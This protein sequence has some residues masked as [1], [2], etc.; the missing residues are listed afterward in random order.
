MSGVRADIT[1]CPKCGSG[2]L[3]CTIG[4]DY[5]VCLECWS[6]WERLRP[7]DAYLTDGEQLAFKTPCDNCAFRG[8]SDERRDAA[9]WRG[10]QQELALGGRFYCHK[11]VPLKQKI[12]EI[13]AGA[14]GFDFPKVQKTID[15]A[16][17]TLPYETYDIEQMRLCRG[18]LNAHVLPH[19]RRMS[20]NA[21]AEFD[22]EARAIEGLHNLET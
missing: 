20:N 17:D 13:K 11:G 8:N 3:S 19:M 22:Q 4:T 14:I 7:E 5:D 15:F 21:E 16:G 18:Y 12:D 9:G 1:A 6:V 10:L 2:R